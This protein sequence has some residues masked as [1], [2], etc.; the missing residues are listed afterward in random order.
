MSDAFL[1]SLIVNLVLIVCILISFWTTEKAGRRPSLMS[2]G[3]LMGLCTLF[4]GV[5]GSLPGG[6]T[7]GTGRGQ[8]LVALTAIWVAA[9][10]LSAGPLG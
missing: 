7:G 5:I 1:S 4:I 8:A 10:A 3:A 2:G 6:V 9:Y